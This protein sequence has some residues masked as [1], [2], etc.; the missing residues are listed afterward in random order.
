MIYIIQAFFFNPQRNVGVCM[1]TQQLLAEA[2]TCC[3]NELRSRQETAQDDV[4]SL[5][6]IHAAYHEYKNRL[7][8]F[9]RM[10]TIE[11]QIAQVLLGN[12]QSREG[13]EMV[14]CS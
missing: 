6:W 3:V 9:S 4:T 13:M 1:S 10:I 12:I 5:P 8:N 11:P 7:Q 2:L 14:S